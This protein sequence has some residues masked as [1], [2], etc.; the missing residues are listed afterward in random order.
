[1]VPVLTTLYLHPRIDSFQCHSWFGEVFYSYFTLSFLLKI[2]KDK[3]SKP[4]SI[5]AEIPKFYFKI[6]QFQEPNKIC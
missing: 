3:T 6:L 5:A 1:M 2:F 4:Y